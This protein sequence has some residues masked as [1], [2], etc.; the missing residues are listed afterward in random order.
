MFRRNK[1]A[2]SA[3]RTAYSLIV[4]FF[5]ISSVL[6][7]EEIKVKEP[8]VVNGD[9]VEYFHEQ[10]KVTGSG[11][12][13]IE[14][15]GVI[16]TCDKVTVYLD[17]REAIAEGNVKVTQ[18][19]G[20]VFTGE[21]VNYNFD[22]RT[23]SVIQGY[24]S[25]RPFYGRAG[26]VAKVSEKQYNLEEG[27]VTTCD[28][29]KPHY[30]IQSKQ[31]KIYLEDKV[32][33]K[34]IFF[35]VGNTPIFYLPI[36]VQPLRE[37][38]KS[39]I[40]VLP[41]KSDE[42]G[43]YVLTAY[44]YYMN[45]KFRGDVLLDYRT[46]KGLAYGVNHYYD[47]GEM[48]VG[49]VKFYRTRKDDR[50]VSQKGKEDNKKEFMDP[51]NRYR[52]Q[53][54]HRWNLPEYTDTTMIAEINYLSDPDIIRDYFYKEYEEL[55]APT[56]FNYIS[57]VTLKPD[58]T[59]EFLIRKRLNDFYTVV[60]RLP[61][62]KI[63]I[64]NHRVFKDAPYYYKANASAVYLNEEFQK[65]SPEQKT[66]NNI[67]IDVSNQISYATRLFNFWNITPFV[68]TEQTFYSR[69]RW[70]DTNLIRGV[71]T[72]G[73]ANQTK[74]YRIFDFSTDFLGLDI[75]KLRHIITP[76][77][78]YSYTGSPTI[79]SENLNQ[80]DGI[81]SIGKQNT[82]S[83]TLENK[84]QT[85]RGAGKDL[86]SIDIATLIVSS[87]YMFRLE[88]NSLN[89]KDHTKKFTNVNLQLELIPY[90]WLYSLSKMTVNTKNLA[91]QT[92]SVDMVGSGGDKWSLGMGYR[93]EKE[94]TG[95]SNLATIEA[96]YKINEKWRVR[97]YE[98][99][100]IKKMLQEQEYTI[101][102]DLHCWIAEVTYNIKSWNDQ[103]WWFAMR[104][105]AFPEIPIGFKRTYHR[106][107]FG[108]TGGGVRYSTDVD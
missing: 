28:L 13:S 11:N 54:R 69:N 53:L 94:L 89:Y 93:Y 64:K 2:H 85:K 71:L 96:M 26:E 22:K 25:A 29:D 100:N 55:Q 37:A 52:Y 17:T 16:L 104:L 68:G 92:A 44:R 19:D 6:A 4:L 65:T 74:F 62:Y 1:I 87:D 32:V 91:V 98:I 84:L 101:S 31:V 5:T 90:P 48:G 47:F 95:I 76:T 20:A 3:Q 97:A 66:L 14:Y 21:K 105:K 43:Y 77:I 40:T 72:A 106:P 70:G 107:Q 51:L 18:K 56:D 15:K 73:L 8:I 12:I 102:R 50:W 27:Y 9:K 35:Y 10:K 79:S 45:D 42:W 58:Y 41:G 34:N 99:F 60:D 80:F 36:Y 61:E 33:A 38:K 86:K 59:S 30:R 67:R 83:L 78:N 103:T 49:A 24:L 57:F 82:I 88:K 75:H 39:H 23:G 81:D 46:K 63:D 108:S 7:E